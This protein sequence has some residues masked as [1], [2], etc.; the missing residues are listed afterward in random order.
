MTSAS[1]N[2]VRFKGRIPD[3]ALPTLVGCIWERRVRNRIGYLD[4]RGD[5]AISPY[6]VA[7]H[8]HERHTPSDISANEL[9]LLAT[10]VCRKKWG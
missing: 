4:R 7:R 9:Y 2:V 6:E 5:D 3:R 1:S 8:I 10:A